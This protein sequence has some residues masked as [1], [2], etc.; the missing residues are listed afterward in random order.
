MTRKL[1]Y[2]NKLIWQESMYIQV[3]ITNK[4]NQYD[5]V[6]KSIWQQINMIAQCNR[7]AKQLDS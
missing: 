7:L 3:N 2:V 5:G 4:A 1:V 6:G